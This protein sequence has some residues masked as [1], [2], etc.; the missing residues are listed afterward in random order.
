MPANHPLLS[1]APSPCRE[2]SWVDGPPIEVEYG[3]HVMVATPPGMQGNT[4][5]WWRAISEAERSS[6][7][8]NFLVE[9]RN[10]ERYLWMSLE[11]WAE[12]LRLLAD[13]GAYTGVKSAE[14][15]LFATAALDQLDQIDALWDEARVRNLNTGVVNT[16][17]YAKENW[18]DPYEF[19]GLSDEDYEELLQLY[20]NA[21]Q[22][23]MCAR[24]GEALSRVRE[25]Y[26][27]EGYA[28]GYGPVQVEAPFRYQTGPGGVTPKVVV[29][30]P[31]PIDEDDFSFED[32]GNGEDGFSE[33]DFFFEDTGNGEDGF[34]EDDFFFEDTGN[35]E[36]TPAVVAPEDDGPWWPW[37]VGGVAVAGLVGGGIYYLYT[38]DS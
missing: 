36:T 10:E 25:K 2:S 24:Y 17:A 14:I 29:Q 37:V 12:Q 35:G 6:F 26:A 1:E 32:T 21:G 4:A 28:P 18:T 11:D 8:Q 13:Q 33:D 7:S 31:A 34:S 3:G 5:D 9:P 15:E 20:E 23:I 38:K 30:D 16:F 27:A 19:V 22:L